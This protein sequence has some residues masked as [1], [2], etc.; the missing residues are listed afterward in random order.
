MQCQ[1]LGFFEGM[2]SAWGHMDIDVYVICALKGNAEITRF[3]LII[4]QM[5]RLRPGGDL[6]IIKQ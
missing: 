2:S 6:V 1:I 5:R 3:T 4:L